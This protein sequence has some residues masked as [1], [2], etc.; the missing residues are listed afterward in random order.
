MRVQDNRNHHARFVFMRVAG[1][2]QHG[3]MKLSP[4]MIWGAFLLAWP[5]ARANDL[6]P[7]PRPPE[8]SASESTTPSAASRWTE[9]EVRKVD[10]A[11]GKL[12]IKH[13][14]IASLDMPGMTMVFRVADPAVL[15][16]V[17]VGDK[18]RFEVIRDQ[19]L[20]VVQRL[21]IMH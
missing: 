18:I 17:Q 3:L 11:A 21:E 13:G 16:L 2:F 1:V 5:Q 10:K 4:L 8:A 7:P 20:Y 14:P 12:T 19:G 9:G 6:A 15:N